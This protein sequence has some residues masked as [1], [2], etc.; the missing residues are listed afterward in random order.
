MYKPFTFTALLLLFCLSLTGCYSSSP[1]DIA[2]FRMP[3]E[4]H[5]TANSYVLE[6][7]DEIEV[8]C[9]KFPIINKQTQ[10]I[11]PDG[12]ISF[13]GIGEIMA[14]GQ[15]PA[16]LAQSLQNK[17]NELYH[18]T[19]T[20]P[21]D[22]KISVFRSKVYYVLGQVNNPGPQTYTGRDTVLTAISQADPNPMAWLQRIQVIRPTR[23]PR[24]L[25]AIF[26]LNYDKMMA[27]GDADKNVLLQEGDVIYVPPTV[28]AWIGLKVEEIVRP[29]ARA[30]TGAYYVRRGTEGNSGG[31]YY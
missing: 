20:N 7:P 9:E 31:Y 29:I 16:Q 8:L 17:I 11:R 26:E 15:T 22:V 6:P 3:N 27:H 4:V 30:F 5:T 10:K 14:A 13:E 24:Y 19:G 1:E 25:P 28:L 2:Y 12:K 23:D 21:V 18:L